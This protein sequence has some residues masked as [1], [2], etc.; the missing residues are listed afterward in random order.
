MEG[1][2]DRQQDFFKKLGTELAS[3]EKPWKSGISVSSGRL[4]I[5]PQC[6]RLGL[7]PLDSVL[8]QVAD[9]H[10]SPNLPVLNQGG[11]RIRRSVIVAKAARI[12]VPVSTV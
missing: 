5:G 10:D 6:L 3:F 1:S 2:S 11:C 12:G 4:D 7:D 8:H 9:R